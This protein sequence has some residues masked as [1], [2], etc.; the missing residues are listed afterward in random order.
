M[1]REAI[2][3]PGLA[4]AVALLVLLLCSG[5]A[6]A[7]ELRMAIGSWCPFVCTREDA[8]GLNGFL[9]DIA[10]AILAREGVQLVLVPSSYSRA[11]AL[12]KDNQVQAM[13]ATKEDAPDLVYPALEQGRT[14]NTFF[15]RADNPWRYGGLASLAPLRRLGIVRDFDYGEL[16]EFIAAHP[17]R[18]ESVIGGDASLRNLKKLLAGR[19]D[20]VVSDAVV[21]EF[22]L[23]LLEQSGR[24]VPAGSLQGAMSFYVAFSPKWPEAQRYAEL[25][26][27]GTRELR[28]SGE[29][30]R[31]L[32]AYG[33]RDWQGR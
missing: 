2:G 9:P 25:I 3:P 21:T 31:I 19:I 16:G 26:S 10:A 29:L 22:Q 33:L 4:R 17:Q 14:S 8:G 12:V 27:S 1:R 30:A 15:V 18:I 7:A 23:K 11:I 28:R 6:R 5:P 32:A 20:A 24:V 13:A